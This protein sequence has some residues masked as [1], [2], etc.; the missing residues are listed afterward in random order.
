MSFIISRKSYEFE[1][2]YI[3]AVVSVLGWGEGM[4]VSSSSS[5]IFVS[6]LSII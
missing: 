2:Q 1:N 4:E 6:Y 3:Y 5:T